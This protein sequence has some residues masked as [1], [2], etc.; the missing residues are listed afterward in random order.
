M[1]LIG[2][3]NWANLDFIINKKA[4][5]DLGE[6]K[7]KA[8]QKALGLPFFLLGILFIAMGIIEKM[9]VFK[10]S[11]FMTIYIALSIIPLGMMLLNK[12]KYFG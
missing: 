7:I 11:I 5:Q 3:L 8:F 9:N 4:K 6:H 1:I 12:K 2:I 10:T